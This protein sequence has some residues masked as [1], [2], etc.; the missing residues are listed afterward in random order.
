M[1][2]NITWGEYFATVG[3]AMTAYYLYI[4]RKYYPNELRRLLSSKKNDNEDET[5]LVEPEPSDQFE[6]A[7]DFSVP[8]EIDEFAEVESLVG[9]VTEAI[10]KASKK[11]MVIGEFK[12]M[13]RMVLKE[14]KHLADSPYRQSINQLIVSECDK[15]GTFTLSEKEVD[16]MWKGL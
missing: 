11:Q 2:S 14:R 5:V 13:L 1:L 8:T 15:Q 6:D 16:V 7:D 3:L 4:G 12:Q 10:Q 9:N